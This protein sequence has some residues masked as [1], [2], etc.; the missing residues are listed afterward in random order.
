VRIHI[1]GG[2]IVNL[3]KTLL[4]AKSGQFR[5]WFAK[6][7]KEVDYD[8][9][10]VPVDIFTFYVDWHYRDDL[11]CK[12]ATAIGYITLFYLANQLKSESAEKHRTQDNCP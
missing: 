12:P 10:K 11:H 2:K 6:C 1:D 5:I 4:E 3:P 9:D 7:P 8:L